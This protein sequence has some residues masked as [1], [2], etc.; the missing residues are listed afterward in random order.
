MTSRPQAVDQRPF[1]EPLPQAIL[2]IEEKSRT[3]PFAWRGQFSPQLVE[4]L[5]RA[6]CPHDAVILDPFCGS[7]TVLREAGSLNRQAVGVELNP[8][9]WIL[10]RIY[11]FMNL[12]RTEREAV[13]E[14]VKAVLGSRYPEPEFFFGLAVQNIEPL[15]FGRFLAGACGGLTSEQRT[16]LEALAILLDLSDAPLTT[17]ALYERVYHLTHLVTR[18]PWS[19]ARIRVRLGDARSLPLPDT[20]VD[21]VLT[22]PP[23]IN[24]FN[25]HQNYRR[26][27]ELLG[28]D[29]L[30][31]AR[32]EIGSN[33]ANRQNRFLTVTQYCLD[34]AKVLAELARVGR[35]DARL[36]LVVGHESNVLGVPFYNAELI[37]SL[38]TESGVFSLAQR[39]QR[40]F[41][42]KFGQSIRED[43]LH[44]C[45]TGGGCQAAVWDALARRIAGEALGAGLRYVA[46]KDRD[47]LLNAIDRTP[48]I[49]GTPVFDAVETR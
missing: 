39:Q 24:V 9:A 14:A 23:Y 33:R 46:N 12:Q 31:V 17:V 36:L 49:V 26:S 35:R 34:M 41:A 38:A 44:L 3:N 15:D 10:S 16:F 8:A 43:L 22:S 13:I 45:P 4:S 27:A 18:L 25:Y 32:S 2:D 48:N 1:K 28:W 40:V 47:A 6:Y 42:N 37:R 21:F 11:Q 7:G 19:T 20:S 30:R 5:L 29:L